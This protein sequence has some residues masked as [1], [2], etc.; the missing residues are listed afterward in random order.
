MR[1]RLAVLFVLL[2]VPCATPQAAER[3]P[4]VTDDEAWKQLPREQP[5]LPGWARTLVGLV[6]KTT[7]HMLELD[8]LQREKNP[9]GA[10]LAGKVRWAA[11]DALG[12]D[13][14]RQVAVF[15]LR[16]AKVKEEEIKALAG[17]IGD[18]PDDDRYIVAF[19]RRLTKAAYTVTDEEVEKLV[20]R[21]GPQTVVGIVHT[22]AYVNFLGRVCL[23]LGVALEPGG[24]LA[25]PEVKWDKDKLDK[26]VTPPRKDWAET[27]K[28]AVPPALLT[29]PDWEPLDFAG[30][31][32][33]LEQQKDR[34]IRVPIPEL[35]PNSGNSG[36]VVWSRV[37]VGYQPEL[38]NKWFA[39]MRTFQKEANLDAVFD[40]SVFWVVTRTNDCFY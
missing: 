25:P 12:W 21:F 15:D 39:T 20:G 29:G 40:N 30:V 14:G 6:P 36:R 3:F 24:P 26:L 18:L 38:T 32:K 11:A 19:A 22:V 31:E 16:R 10:V 4:A 1:T 35:P 34:K 7:A 5:P 23:G 28:A 9:L 13:Y 17:P 33:N 8:H 2:A 37:S 27:L